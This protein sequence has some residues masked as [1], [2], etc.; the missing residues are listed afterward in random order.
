MG[1]VLAKITVDSK[2]RQIRDISLLQKHFRFKCKRCATLCCGLGGP[3]L[4]KKDVEGIEEAGYYMKD[5]LEPAKS[6]SMGM[7]VVGSNLKN[8]ENGAC[9]FLKFE[10]KQ[11]RFKCSIYDVRPVLCRL[12]PFDFD[13]VS[14]NIVLLKFIPCCRGLNS[15]DGEVVDEEWIKSNLVAPLFE[16]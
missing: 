16:A 13:K 11:N 3:K 14:S 9:I 2:L 10:A 5:F 6:E 8:R 1:E 4:S 7:L 15:P 12:Y